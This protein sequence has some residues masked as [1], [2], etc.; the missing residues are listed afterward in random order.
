M[1]TNCEPDWDTFFGAFMWLARRHL[2]ST[3][4][5]LDH[6]HECLRGAIAQFVGLLPES[7]RGDYQIIRASFCDQ[8]NSGGANVIPLAS[9]V[10]F[11]QLVRLSYGTY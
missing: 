11:G 3:E 8:L 4:E 2:W 7:V 5:R 6:P 10:N 9:N 1:N